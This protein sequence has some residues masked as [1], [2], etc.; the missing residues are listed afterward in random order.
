MSLQMVKGLKNENHLVLSLSV[1]KMRKLTKRKAAGVRPSVAYD[2][3]DLWPP[4]Y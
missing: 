1:L 4:G 2:S 3:T